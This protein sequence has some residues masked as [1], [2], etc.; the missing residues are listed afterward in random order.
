MPSQVVILLYPAYLSLAQGHVYGT[1]P[2]FV[3]AWRAITFGRHTKMFQIQVD[4]LDFSKRRVGA[5]VS[6]NVRM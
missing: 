4:L 6:Q 2:P 5:S 1:L 3:Q